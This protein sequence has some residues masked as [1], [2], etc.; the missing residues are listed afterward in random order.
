[1]VIA[2]H[3]TW[4]DL[5]EGAAWDGLRVLVLTDIVDSTREN[6]RV[7]DAAMAEVWREHDERAR[8]LIRQWR[9]LEIGRSDG[10]L[11]LFDAP[12]PAAAFAAG[13]HAAQPPGRSRCRGR[14]RRDAPAAGRA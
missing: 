1:M 14:P 5:P 6:D 9:G 2:R 12:A 10:F 4:P 11:L 7:G 3:P 8:S 13:Y